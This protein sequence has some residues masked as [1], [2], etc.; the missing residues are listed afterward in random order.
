VFQK[1]RINVVDFGGGVEWIPLFLNHQTS[2]Y[3]KQREAHLQNHI[4][5]GGPSLQSADDGA[6]FDGSE[7]DQSVVKSFGNQRATVYPS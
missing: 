1:T 6:L 7:P 2:R 5:I 4:V 3:L